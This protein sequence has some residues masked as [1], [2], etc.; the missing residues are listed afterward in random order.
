MAYRKDSTRKSRQHSPYSRKQSGLRELEHLHGA[1]LQDLLTARPENRVIRV[2]FTSHT[3][4]VAHAIVQLVREAGEPPAMFASGETCVN[5]AAKAMATAR[6]ALEE[7]QMDLVGQPQ[8][9][10]QS[11]RY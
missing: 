11:G 3:S 1:S 9:D 8:Y 2:S 10:P 4:R 6:A 5:V 7:D